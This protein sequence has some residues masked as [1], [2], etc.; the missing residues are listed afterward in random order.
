MTPGWLFSTNFGRQIH[1]RYGYSTSLRIVN[2]PSGWEM[3]GKQGENLRLEMMNAG[4][5]TH[6]NWYLAQWNS[7][8]VFNRQVS[9]NLVANVPLTPARPAVLPPPFD[10]FMTVGPFGASQRCAWGW[11]GSAWAIF[12]T[13]NNRIV[14]TTATTPGNLVTTTTQVPGS[15]NNPCYDWNVSIAFTNSMDHGMVASGLGFVAN[16]RIIA[17][18]QNDIAIIVNGSNPSGTNSQTY[19][20]PEELT[21]AGVSLKPGSEG[22]LMWGPTTIK[23]HSADNKNLMFE[24][25]AEGTLCFI[26]MPTMEF[27]GYDMHSGQ[28]LWT[29]AP[30]AEI[31][32]FGYFGYVSLMH[33]YSTHIAYGKLYT[34]GYTGHVIAYDL[35]NGTELWRFES[36][37]N[38]TIF[39]DYTLFIGT[40]ADGK[41]YVGTHEHSADTPLFKGAHLSVLNATTGEVIWEMEGWA[42]PQTMAIADGTLIYWDNYD[43]TVKAI[44]KGPSAMT[45]EAPSAGVTVGTSL[46]IRGTVMDISPGTKQTEQAA[47]FPN[48]VPAVSDES[49]GTWM[50]Y[51]YMQKSRPRDATGVPVTIDVVDA[52]GNFRNI[53]STTSDSTGFF[54]LEWQPDIPG[55]YTVIASFAGS[56]SY[57]PSYAETA[58]T[59]N[60]APEQPAEP[61]P[62]PPSIAD[63]Y[64]LPAIG[65]VIAAIAVVGAVVVLLLRK[66][67]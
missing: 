53:G 9:G 1:P 55:K 23:T 32:P 63:Q 10:S 47:R 16:V 49:M 51:V 2:V 6:P 17:A 42:H 60:P 29:T 38:R 15:N 33:V 35:K 11:T 3:I 57:W 31:N 52:N 56:K 59:A 22:S 26:Q 50:A 36:P 66:R 4:N 5:T 34:T 30:E 25:G 21:M 8:R 13:T 67:P 64:F 46:V 65:G 40:I 12:D 37:T 54:S 58:F 20:Y 27:V 45:M 41:V 19:F 7:S 14:N 61:E 62:A 43:H 48:G 28:K 18:D 44:D 24:R 39:R